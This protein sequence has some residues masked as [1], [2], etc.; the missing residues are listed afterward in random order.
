MAGDAPS[1]VGGLSPLPVDA[2][3]PTTI[4]LYEVQISAS[5]PKPAAALVGAFTM[6][7]NGGLTFTAKALPPLVSASI[8]AVAED[9][10]NGAATVSFHTATGMNY[11]LLTSTSAQGGW[12]PV[13]GAGVVSGDGTVQ[14]LI[15]YNATDPVRF[16]RLQT[17]Y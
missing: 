15:D 1:A 4:A 9:W 12:S 14:S 10:V 3:N 6:D 13:A 17:T 2:L 5:N 7:V 16:Y 11:K 8:V